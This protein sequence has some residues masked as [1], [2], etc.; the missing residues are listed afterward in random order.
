MVNVV[1]LIL[2]CIH[3]IEHKLFDDNNLTVINNNTQIEDNIKKT[4][5]LCKYFIFRIYY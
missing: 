2:Y 3:I 5:K 1:S 4:T